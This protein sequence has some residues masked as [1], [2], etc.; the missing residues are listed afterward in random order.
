M[1][2]GFRRRWVPDYRDIMNLMTSL[3]IFLFLTIQN[4]FCNDTT[5]CL[6]PVKLDSKWGFIDNNQILKISYQFDSVGY[7]SEDLALAKANGLWGYIN[8]KGTF[9]IKPQF[10]YAES[11]SVVLQ[12]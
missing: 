8:E 5:H 9:I 2:G 10:K 11:F 1:A 6:F 12:M 4:A 3:F 7:F